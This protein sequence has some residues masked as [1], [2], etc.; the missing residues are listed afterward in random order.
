MDQPCYHGY[1]R[2]LLGAASSQNFE[3]YYHFSFLSQVQSASSSIKHFCWF[4]NEAH[5]QKKGGARFSR[6]KLKIKTERNFLS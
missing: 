5:I 4:A 6:P 3:T 2:T 1:K